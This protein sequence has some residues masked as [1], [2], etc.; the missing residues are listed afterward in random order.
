MTD[1]RKIGNKNRSAKFNVV[2][3]PNMSTQNLNFKNMG[4]S[5][6]ELLV[7]SEMMFDDTVYFKDINHD[8]K[9]LDI[10]EHNLDVCSNLIIDKNLTINGSFIYKKHNL[11]DEIDS[12]NAKYR[13]FFNTSKLFF[14]KGSNSLHDGE[15]SDGSTA[16]FIDLSG[17]YY[18]KAGKYYELK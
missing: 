18:K 17:I 12:I 5:G 15:L 11:S 2:N 10:I 13:S 8:I 14:R 4:I 1:W 9:K 3:V 6:S 7:N 16:Q